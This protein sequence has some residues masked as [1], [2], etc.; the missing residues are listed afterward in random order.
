MRTIQAPTLHPSKSQALSM[1]YQGYVRLAKL[2]INGQVYK[3]K[4]VKKRN[5]QYP[6]NFRKN[7]ESFLPC[8]VN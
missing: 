5:R 7:N 4:N 3:T 2:G 8:K 1:K 6:K